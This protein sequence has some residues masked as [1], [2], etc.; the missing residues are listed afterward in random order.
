MAERG[1]GEGRALAGSRAARNPEFSRP[2][3]NQRLGCINHK[4]PLKPWLDSLG[5]LGVGGRDKSADSN[6]LTMQAWDR[7]TGHPDTG[8]FSN[9]EEGTNTRGSATTN[10]KCAK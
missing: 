3:E 1:C 4:L 6:H 10:D 8:E 7:D 9:W 5:C 2:T